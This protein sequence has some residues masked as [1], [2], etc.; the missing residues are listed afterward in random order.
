MY[1][2]GKLAN[3]NK[4]TA[5][6]TTWALF[7]RVV[8]SNSF[9]ACTCANPANAGNFGQFEFEFLPYQ[10][11]SAKTGPNAITKQLPSPTSSALAC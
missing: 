8:K 6:C 11:M 5:G 10:I 1:M 4:P 9:N 2:L 3:K 7:G